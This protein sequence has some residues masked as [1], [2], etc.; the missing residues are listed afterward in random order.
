MNARGAASAEVRQVRHL[1]DALGSGVTVESRGRMRV[2]AAPTVPTDRVAA[3][4]IAVERVLANVDAWAESIA[5]GLAL[6]RPNLTI[7]LFPDRL[8]Y[9]EYLKIEGLSGLSGS[10]GATHPVRGLSV[11]VAADEPTMSVDNRVVIAHE[12]IHLWALRSGLCPAVHAWP[13]WLHEGLALLWD[14]TAI[15]NGTQ[16]AFR[17]SAAINSDVV[18]PVNPLRLAD[19]MRMARGFDC[20]AFLRK[21][22]SVNRRS[23][24]EDYAAGWALTYA[25]AN[26][27]GG[28]PLCELWQDLT[29]RNL[30]PSDGQPIELHV[31]RWAKARFGPEWDRMTAAVRDIGLS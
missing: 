30:H 19:W 17:K 24:A 1:K 28:S 13:R 4:L 9:D 31:L 5:G 11:A 10:W 22:M 21:D 7:G 14:H 12:C 20:E 23:H 15:E 8:S 3:A 26:M 18:P 6:R 25:L 29:L 27:H 2:V 16:T